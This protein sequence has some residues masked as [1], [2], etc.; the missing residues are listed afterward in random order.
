MFY[1]TLRFVFLLD[2]IDIPWSYLTSEA[3]VPSG[4]MA[5]YTSYLHA[6]VVRSPPPHSYLYISWQFL[7]VV[8]Y[9]FQWHWNNEVI[10]FTRTGCPSRTILISLPISKLLSGVHLTMSREFRHSQ[11]N[12]L[13][14]DS[15]PAQCGLFQWGGK[16]CLP[17]S[18]EKIQVSLH[19]VS[20]FLGLHVFLENNGWFLCL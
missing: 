4:I 15:T 3:I 16:V 8:I 6:R 2:M 19:E 13:Y 7:T 18:S 11:R 14:N 17:S 20:F 10:L 12:V 1:S 9:H 5:W